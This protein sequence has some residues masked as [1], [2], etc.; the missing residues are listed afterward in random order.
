ML[1]LGAF[2][3]YILVHNQIWKRFKSIKIKSQKE[4]FINWYKILQLNFYY[5]F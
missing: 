1:E 2:L 5:K 3:I 4:S